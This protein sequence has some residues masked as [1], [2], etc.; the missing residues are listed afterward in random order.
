MNERKRHAIIVLGMHRSG[1]SALAGM[2][3]LL[4]AKL[5]NRILPAGRGNPKGHFEPQHIVNIHDRIL[6]SAGTTWS[7]WEEI[8]EA[9]FLSAP[10]RSFVDELVEAVRQDYAQAP[11]F[12]VKDP[13]MCRLMPLW[14]RVLERI[15]VKPCFAISLR[16]PLEVARSLQ[17]RDGLS[18]AQGCLAWLRHV[19]DA[20]R[21]TR[22][23]PRGFV[24]YGDLFAEPRAVIERLRTDLGIEWPRQVEIVLDEIKDFLDPS[25]K[26]QLAH[27]RDIDDM[28]DFSPWL[29]RAY[30]SH[31]ALVLSSNKEDAKRQLDS[32]QAAFAAFDAAFT[33]VFKHLVEQHGAE[34]ATLRETLTERNNQV[35]ALGNTLAKQN[36]KLMAYNQ[37]VAEH[38]REL[39]GLR[40]A[41]DERNKQLAVF[42]K[43]FADRNKKLAALERALTERERL[44]GKLRN[45][46][47][48]R[49]QSLG[50][51]GDDNVRL[52][53][54]VNA[55]SQR[56]NLIESSS[57][58]QA[59]L[60]LRWGLAVVPKPIRRG[61]RQVFTALWWLLTPHR[62]PARLRELRARRDKPPLSPS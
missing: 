52:T 31:E 53:D 48:A 14:Y 61:S 57:I 60:P 30:E 1:T 11:L 23:H 28:G 7:S 22:G 21:H 34:L 6:A 26:N 10:S 54:A 12:M 16:N 44:I 25:L 55:I 42:H 37:T 58:W 47:A 40:N 29:R 4:G 24:N 27:E 15:D 13:R 41:L 20:E 39:G 32:L 3:G 45:E 56:L 59:T 43:A 38:S 9:W 46:L 17:N 35:T 19:L 49:E 36:D 62:I 51:L 2:L 33:P 50:Q 8:P 18:I 5:P